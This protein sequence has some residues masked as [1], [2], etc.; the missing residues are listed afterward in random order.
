MKVGTIDIGKGVTMGTASIILYDTKIGD[1]ARIEPLT[2]V[3]KGEFIPPHTVWA[4]APAER[5]PVPAPAAAGAAQAAV[6]GASAPASR[7][8]SLL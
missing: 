8:A 5:V 4:G 3:M 7:A 1:W 2:V 6:P